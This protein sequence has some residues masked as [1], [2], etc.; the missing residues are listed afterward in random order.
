M[1]DISCKIRRRII[2][3][4]DWRDARFA[5]QSRDGRLS[6]EFSTIVT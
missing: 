3:V 4:L 1:S 5:G 6:N 2:A